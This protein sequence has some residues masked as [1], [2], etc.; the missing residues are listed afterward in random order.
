M[1]PEEG[2]CLQSPINASHSTEALNALLLILSSPHRALDS[3]EGV[4]LDYGVR[5]QT[6]VVSPFGTYSIGQIFKDFLFF[7]SFDIKNDALQHEMVF[8]N[9]ETT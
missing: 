8:F 5:Y 6:T 7:F 9:I 3:Q 1:F 4:C 2:L